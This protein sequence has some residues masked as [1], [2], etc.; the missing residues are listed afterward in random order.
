MVEGTPTER[1]AADVKPINKKLKE[2]RK[3]MEAARAARDATETK[4]EAGGTGGTGGVYAASLAEEDERRKKRKLDDL[5]HRQQVEMADVT[6]IPIG[7]GAGADDDT[8]FVIHR[9]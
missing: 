8:P 2:C 1:S 3:L 6:G 7:G 9:K 5:L 4:E